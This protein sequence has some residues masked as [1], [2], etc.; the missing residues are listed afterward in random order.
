MTIEKEPAAGGPIQMFADGACKGNPGPGGWG[1]LLRHPGAEKELFGAEL[2][3]DAV[4]RVTVTVP[5]Q[6][7]AVVTAAR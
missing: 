1:V 6:G 3:V 7:V 5:P 2:R 4:G